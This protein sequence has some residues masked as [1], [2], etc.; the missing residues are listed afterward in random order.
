[1]R[2]MPTEGQGSVLCSSFSA[3]K[4]SKP[5]PRRRQHALAALGRPEDLQ[6]LGSA[7]G[8]L[9]LVSAIGLRF[10]AALRARGLGFRAYGVF[11]IALS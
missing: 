10:R 4:K 5:R 11:T 3:R 1:M 9:V 2:H 6:G 7:S 8:S